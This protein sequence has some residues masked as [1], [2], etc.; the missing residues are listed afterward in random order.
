MTNSCFAKDLGGPDMGYAMNVL[1]GNPVVRCVLLTIGRFLK[2]QSFLDLHA[3]D[4]PTIRVEMFITLGIPSDASNGNVKMF[5][6]LEIISD[7]GK[8]NVVLIR[9]NTTAEAVPR[10]PSTKKISPKPRDKAV[11]SITTVHSIHC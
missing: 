5:I 4:A 11:D 2:I 10:V 8:G 3:K 6:K 9:C 7:A 1:L